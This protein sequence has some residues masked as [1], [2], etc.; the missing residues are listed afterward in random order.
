[1]LNVLGGSGDS[2][3]FCL[4]LSTALI[5]SSR[6]C[7]VS[8]YTVFNKKILLSQHALGKTSKKKSVK[9]V[10]L[11]KKGGGHRKKSNFEGVNKNDI[12]IGGGGVKTNVTF[13][14]CFKN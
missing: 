14:R 11:C 3:P 13:S 12:L 9:R 4:E 1:M 7:L 10:T 8:E 5:H 6:P 2:L